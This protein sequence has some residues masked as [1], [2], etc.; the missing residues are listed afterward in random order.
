MSS[1]YLYALQGDSGGPLIVQ[2]ASDKRYELVGVV[3][4]GNGCARP[5]Y[6]GVYTRVTRYMTWIKENSK[7]GC[8]CED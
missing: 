5:S 6:P 8:F 3:S 1:I 4:W 2:R 7:D